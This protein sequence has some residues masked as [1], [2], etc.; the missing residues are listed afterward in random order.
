MTASKAMRRLLILFKVRSSL[1]YYL[2]LTIAIPIDLFRSILNKINFGLSEACRDI[3]RKLC[4][5]RLVLT[6]DGFWFVV[7]SYRELFIALIESHEPKSYT[8]I[9][10]VLRSELNRG[11]SCTFVDVGAHIGTYALRV[12][13]ALGKGGIVVAVEPNSHT[14]LKLN[15]QINALNNIITIPKAAY[16]EETK[17][18]FYLSSELGWASTKGSGF[19]VCVDTVTIDAIVDTLSSEDTALIIKV[20]V[21]GGE[22]EVL[23]GGWKTLNVRRPVILCEVQQHNVERTRTLLQDVS[24]AMIRL[25]G[26]NYVLVPHERQREVLEEIEVTV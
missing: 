3:L 13:K 15:A 25:E 22:L 16:S 7:P 23:I 9:Y 21:E 2:E 14:L 8:F 1:R 10:K 6:S 20:D 4:R 26:L 24:Y 11:K 19:Y 18:K 17:I 12:A 5:F